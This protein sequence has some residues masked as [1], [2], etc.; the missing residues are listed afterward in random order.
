MLAFTSSDL[1]SLLVLLAIVVIFL[2][3]RSRGSK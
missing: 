1:Q 2:V 3:M